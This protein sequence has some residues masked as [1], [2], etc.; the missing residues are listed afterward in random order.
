M[1]LPPDTSLQATR[2]TLENSNQLH[3]VNAWRRMCDEEDDDDD[4]DD[5]ELWGCAV[6]DVD[7]V[8]KWL[9]PCQSF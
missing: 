1:L 7:G 6:D 9:V 2:V 8:D 4:E 3:I 5:D